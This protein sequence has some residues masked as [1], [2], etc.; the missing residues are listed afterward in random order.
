MTPISLPQRSNKGMSPIR[1]GDEQA[2]WMN[3]ARTHNG[4]GRVT[5]KKI[6][7]AKTSSS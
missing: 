7:Q 4:P 1:F 5:P 3:K 2:S 6:K